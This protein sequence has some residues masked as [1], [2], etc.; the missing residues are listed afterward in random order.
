MPPVRLAPCPTCRF[1]N[2]A[3]VASLGHPL[4]CY[5]C[6]ACFTAFPIWL[7]LHAVLQQGRPLGLALLAVALA[8]AAGAVYWAAGN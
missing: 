4:R 7:P 5:R 2:R 8:L 1:R 3:D 6:G